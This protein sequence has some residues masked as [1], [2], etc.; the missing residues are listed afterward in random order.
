[1]R[2]VKQL[3]GQIAQDRKTTF[4]KTKDGNFERQSDDYDQ[5]ESDDHSFSE[6]YESDQ[7]RD[8]IS[9]QKI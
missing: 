8:F 2:E 6:T 4:V 1:M 9:K 5:Q 3:L 7:L